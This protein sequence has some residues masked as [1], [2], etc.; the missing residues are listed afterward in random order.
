[1]VAPM[2]NLMQRDKGKEASAFLPYSPLIPQDSSSPVEKGTLAAGIRS[3]AGTCGGASSSSWPETAGQGRQGLTGPLSL[4][5]PGP[6]VLQ[7]QARA[8]GICLEAVQ[9]A[10][11]QEKKKNNQQKPQNKAKEWLSKGTTAN[12]PVLPFRFQVHPWALKRK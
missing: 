1:M 7:L 8:C 11:E 2:G 12:L 5:P 4:E 6:V 9:A 10:R 3:G